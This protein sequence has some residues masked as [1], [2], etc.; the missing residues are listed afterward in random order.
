MPKVWSIWIII[1]F[2]LIREHRMN[3]T[4]PPSRIFTA[5]F[6]FVNYV[7]EEKL[8]TEV[9]QKKHYIGLYILWGSRTQ[10]NLKGRRKRSI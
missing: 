10:L 4:S 6:R 3:P 2:A 5:L 1:L 8:A 9:L 7:T